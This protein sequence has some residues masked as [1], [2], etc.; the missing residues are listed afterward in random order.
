MAGSRRSSSWKRRSTRTRTIRPARRPLSPIATAESASKAD[1]AAS[2]WDAGTCPYKV[3]TYPVDS[4]GD[5][6]LGGITGV[7]HDE[8]NFDRRDQNVVQYWTPDRSAASSCKLAATTNETKTA[9]LNP[10]DEGALVAYNHGP[11]YA[12]FAYEGHKDPSTT[13]TQGRRLQRRR[14]ISA[15][16]RSRLVCVYE[17]IKRTA[18]S[19][20]ASITKRKSWLANVVYAM[21]GNEFVYQYQ[22]GKDG[23]AEYRRHAAQ[24]QQQH[25]GVQVHLHEAHVL[26]RD[27]HEGRQQLSGNLQ[28]RLE[29][30]GH[31]RRQRSGRRRSRHTARVLIA[32]SRFGAK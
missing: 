20:G 13:V 26:H 15:S 9:T 21:G 10:H 19:G 11:L 28:L 3:S 6:T 14:Q 5:L 4:F 22:N 24:L 7:G 17:E 32:R 30:A 16:A 23:A 29:P 8:G 1:G 12:F 25:V 31:R 2:S 18:A 27:V